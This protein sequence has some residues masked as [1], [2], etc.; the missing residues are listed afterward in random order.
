VADHEVERLRLH[1]LEE[2]CGV[3]LNAANGFAEVGVRGSTLQRRERIRT[4]I[5]DGDA[6]SEQRQTYG[7]SPGATPEIEHIQSA[8]A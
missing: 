2:I 4:G 7:I 1:V 6:V 8:I 5:D 3:T